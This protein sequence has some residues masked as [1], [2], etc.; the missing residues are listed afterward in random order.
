MT[1][2]VFPVLKVVMQY[3]LSTHWEGVRVNFTAYM[4][5]FAAVRNLCERFPFRKVLD[6]ESIGRAQ[7]VYEL[8]LEGK[9]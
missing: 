4:L 2:L 7:E 5:K 8:V 6:E 1:V 3:D 9:Q